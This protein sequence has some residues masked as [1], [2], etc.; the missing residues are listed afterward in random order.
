MSLQELNRLELQFLKAIDFD[1]GVGADEQLCACITRMLIPPKVHPTPSSSSSCSIAGSVASSPCPA[2]LS[3]LDVERWTTDDCIVAG[4]KG[5]G[6]GSGFGDAVPMA[7][8]RWT[9]DSVVDLEDS[10]ARAEAALAASSATAKGG[11]RGGNGTEAGDDSGAGEPAGIESDRPG[12]YHYEFEGLFQG[13]GSASAML[14]EDVCGDWADEDED[15]EDDVFDRS[16]IDSDARFAGLVYKRQF[17]SRGDLRS[18]EIEGL[19]RQEQEQMAA[20]ME[21]QRRQAHQLMQQRA[22]AASPQGTPASPGAAHR[23]PPGP[24]FGFGYIDVAM[25]APPQSHAAAAAGSKRP[26]GGDGHS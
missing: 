12:F 26:L 13:Q 23:K 18:R 3:A 8:D 16:A 5:G 15:V 2:A 6:G 25:G 14:V 19:F 20:Y 4:P 7:G 24:V 22:G 1:L 21:A 9:P 11:S 10:L 17:G